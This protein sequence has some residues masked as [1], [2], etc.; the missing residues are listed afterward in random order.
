MPHA[1][2]D[3]FISPCLTTVCVP[4]QL[5][6]IR[7]TTVCVPRQLD[8]IRLT[9]VCVPRQLDQIRTSRRHSVMLSSM[10]LKEIVMCLED[11]INY[12]AQPDAEMGQ[13]RAEPLI[14]GQGS[15]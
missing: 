3:A 6:Q 15:L 14:R 10:N 8:Q 5:D 12:F 7:L 9:T 4:R 2:S 1:L 13:S 11:L